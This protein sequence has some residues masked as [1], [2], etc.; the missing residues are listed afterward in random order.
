MEDRSPTAGRGAGVS[1]G[2]TPP[3]DGDV[4]LGFDFRYDSPQ[5]GK[6]LD[7]ICQLAGPGGK[8]LLLHMGEGDNLTAVGP[9]GNSVQLG[10]LV[11]GSWYHVGSLVRTDGWVTVTLTDFA[12][13]K[14]RHVEFA[15]FMITMPPIFTNVAFISAALDERTG[16]WALD[17]VCMAGS[18]ASSRAKWLPFDQAPLSELRKSP[19]KVFAYYFIYTSGYSDED[20]GLAWYTRTVLNP[21][22]LA[23]CHKDRAG[24]GTELLYRPFPRPPMAGGLDREE[25]R[26]RGMEEEIRLARQQGLDGFLVDF[27]AKPK[28]SIGGEAEFTKDS[29]AIL[30]AA[31]QVDPDF[32]IIPAV[33]SSVVKEGINGEGDTGCDPV[34]Y[35]NSPIIK[36]ISGHPATLRLPDGRIVFSRWLSETHSVAWWSRVMDQMAKNGHPIAFLPQFNSYGRLKEFSKIAYGMAHWGPRSPQAYDWL[37]RVR[38]YDG[39]KCVFPVVEQDVRTRGCESFESCNSETLRRLWNLAIAGPADWVFI[40][41]WSDFTEQA[42]QPATC[43]GFAPYDINAYYTQWFKTGVQPEIVRDTLYYFYRKHHTDV[44]QAKGAKWKFRDEGGPHG[45]SGTVEHNE[46]EVLAFLTASGTLRVDVAGKVCQM[47]A[48]PGITSFKV[49][50]PKGLAFVPQFSLIRNGQIILSKSGHFAVMDKVEFPNM[51]YCSGVIR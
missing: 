51:L 20:P 10:A 4:Y 24:A 35:A 21:S 6:G 41:T 18:V 17:N 25:V 42:M 48:A 14:N 13:D 16:S 45:E 27:W 12:K 26:L 32:K 34:E 39:V 40:D 33:Y 5:R 31:M 30:D 43:I 2:F 19:R 8:G 38:Q 9:E 46:I 15:P 1:Y 47:E 23:S 28:Q 11:P 22:T 7:L 50:L 29:F 36:R 44:E 37:S 49:P 3:P